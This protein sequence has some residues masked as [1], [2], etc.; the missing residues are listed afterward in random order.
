MTFSR[1][2]E[3]NGQPNA[4][5]TSLDVPVLIVGGGPTG[6]LQ[7]YLLSKLGIKSL[8]IERYTKR[9]DA[10]KAHALC[11]RSL[12]I[13]RQFG[14]D[15]VHIRSLGAQRDDAYWVNFL[16]TLSGNVVGRLPYERMDAA[17]LD[18]TPEMIHNIPQPE[19]EKYVA[20]EISKL[21]NIE[22][23]KGI[24][25]VSLEQHLDHVTTTVEDRQLGKHYL[26]KSK[27]VIGCDG[28]RSK[29]RKCLGIE[30]EGEDSCKIERENVLRL[31]DP[32]TDRM[33][34]DET[35]M[36]I[37][38]SADL[39]SIVGERVGMLHWLFDPLASGFIIAYNLSGNAVLITNFDPEKYPTE[40]WNE[41]LCREVLTGAIGHDHCV[42]I[43][44]YRPWV[45]SRKVAKSYRRGSVFLAGDA[46][47]SFPPTGG[48]GLNSSLADVH[49][50]AFKIAAVYQEIA[51][52]P[53]LDTYEAERRHVA[54]VNSR[55]SV[56][57]GQTIFSL[58]KTLG[59]A[60]VADVAEARR[61][62][63]AAIGDQDRM[64]QISKGVEAQREHF[65][66]LGLHIG[67]IYGDTG[68]P[69]NASHYTPTYTPGARLPH[70]WLGQIVPSIARQLQPVNLGYVHEMSFHEAKARS[71]ST[72]DLCGPDAWTVLLPSLNSSMDQTAAEL[73][74]MH[75]SLKF[76]I[77]KLGREFDLL[78]GA[79][80]AAWA[81]DSGLKSGSGLLVRPDQHILAVL[82]P[83]TRSSD[84]FQL[85]QQ[86]LG[87][88]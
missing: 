56:K 86:F 9:L 42:K 15:L 7:G 18:L 35:M 57:N 28:A 24:S 78:P 58:L 66:N 37:H 21:N 70:A 53:L 27:Y 22:V 79:A 34:S 2:A 43:L 85:V 38:F 25:F 63:K 72:L 60:E 76:H 45:L 41:A 26:I 32:I 61:N 69:A 80:G 84:I 44:S 8:I 3:T 6:L 10:P 67:Y 46:A 13:C 65:D 33:A 47:H 88:S 49:N 50:L 62:L 54:E 20:E 5:G 71:Y 4:S 64:Q 68:I 74:G 19:F 55:Q 52:E 82:N 40:A 36:T 77:F 83:E 59:T 14:L 16:T 39:R 48:L 75:H 73:A 87:M 23:Q 1:A 51:K 31:G 17:V 12:E 11:P 81:Q 30:S 29:V